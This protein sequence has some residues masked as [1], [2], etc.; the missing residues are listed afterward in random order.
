MEE[1]DPVERHKGKDEDFVYSFK[2]K[3]RW[4]YDSELIQ[5]KELG[6][7]MSKERRSSIP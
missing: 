6:K 7:I 3:E 2:G 1:A 5:V 4:L